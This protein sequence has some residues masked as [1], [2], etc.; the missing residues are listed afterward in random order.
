MKFDSNQVIDQNFICQGFYEKNFIEIRDI[1]KTNTGKLFE[2]IDKYNGEKFTIEKIHVKNIDKLIWKNHYKF[3]G[4]KGIFLRVLN[5]WLEKSNGT[6]EN[7]GDISYTFF[8]QMEFWEF[9]IEETLS[10]MEKNIDTHYERVFVSHYTR[11]SLFI[12]FLKI[13]RLLWVNKVNQIEIKRSNI[14]IIRESTGYKL[15]ILASSISLNFSEKNKEQK[16][17][18]YEK[19]NKNYYL[20]QLKEIKEYLFDEEFLRYVELVFKYNY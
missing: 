3:Q 17:F 14:F 19:H 20:H 7:S 5:T 4:F 1:R 16:E 9:A 8:I 13:F 12:E 2:I 11:L 10:E 18:E 6:D 15:K